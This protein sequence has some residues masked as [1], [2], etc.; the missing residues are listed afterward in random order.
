M[1]KKTKENIKIAIILIIIFTICIAFWGGVYKF[2][3]VNECL[4]EFSDEFC[5]E[6]GFD[7]SR[8]LESNLFECVV[9]VPH[10]RTEYTEKHIYLKEDI[11][12]CWE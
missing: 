4:K 11:R 6:D 8:M 3:K 5:I 10:D 12:R 7:K 9:V 1:K 2:Y